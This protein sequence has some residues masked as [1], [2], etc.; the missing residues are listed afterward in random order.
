MLDIGAY[1]FYA[2]D[3]ALTDVYFFPHHGLL[4]QSHLLLAE[5]DTN[6][7]PAANAG[8][9]RRCVSRNGDALQYQLLAHYRNLDRL[10]FRDH[11][12]AHSYLA[13]VDPLL[14]DAQHFS[15]ELYPI[16]PAGSS[17]DRTAIHV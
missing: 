8:G 7:L 16:H 4:L 9:R 15:K 10:I 13:L 14:M 1:F 6:L 17:I 12:L 3:L 5:R 11:V 2:C